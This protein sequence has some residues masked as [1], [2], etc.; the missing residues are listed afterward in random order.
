MGY[1]QE[2]E[3]LVSIESTDPDSDHISS[4][5]IVPSSLQPSEPYDFP[6]SIASPSKLKMAEQPSSPAKSLNN[7]AASVSLPAPPSGAPPQSLREKLLNLRASSRASLA[8]KPPANDQEDLQNVA[9][10]PCISPPIIEP[11]LSIEP[12]RPDSQPSKA[13]VETLLPV[14]GLQPHMPAYPS[15]LAEEYS[16]PQEEI[17]LRPTHLGDSEY[18][19]SLPMNTRVRDQ[20]VSTISYYRSAVEDFMKGE[21]PR[22]AVLDKIETMLHRVDLVATHVDL[23]SEGAVSHGQE[24]AEDE[25]IWAENCSAKF[26]FLGHLLNSIRNCDLHISIVARAGRLLDILETFLKGRKLPC[27]RLDTESRSN[28]AIT[29]GRLRVTLVPSEGAEKS[30]LPKPA[31][32][33]L[34][35]DSSFNLKAPQVQ[36]LRDDIGATDR[37]APVLYLLVYCSGEHIKRCMPEVMDTQDRTR[38]LVSFVTQTRHRVGQLLPEEPTTNVLAEE[39]A[40]FVKT[41]GLDKDWALPPIRTIESVELIDTQIYEYLSSSNDQESSTTKEAIMGRTPAKPKRA[42]VGEYLIFIDGLLMCVSRIRRPSP[43]LLKSVSERQR[44]ET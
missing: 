25:A 38:S 3:A 10:S 40:E 34:A 14:R 16:Q 39:V 23:D 21:N 36:L 4:S 24:A 7:S 11:S 17:S 29:D 20:Y 12:R 9:V 15:K 19:V 13:L 26:Q 2:D 27:T 30:Y 6:I 32:L 28:L 5:F 8:P 43:Y 35:F 42:L 37:L 44:R 18:I 33:V 31:N 41:G 22:Q 1:I